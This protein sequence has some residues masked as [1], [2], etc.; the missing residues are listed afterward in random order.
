M[1][2]EHTCNFPQRGF[3]GLISAQEKG[4]LH[5]KTLFFPSQGL[6]TWTAPKNA[7]E[8]KN[9]LEVLVTI[10]SGMK[11]LCG[12]KVNGAMHAAS[13][14]HAPTAFLVSL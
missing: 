7:L 14:I 4:S 6:M 5:Q 9:T 3:H 12:Y 11:I 13:R 2:P 1:Q 10:C 8:Q